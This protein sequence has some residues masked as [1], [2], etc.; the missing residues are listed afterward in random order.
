MLPFRIALLSGKA[1]IV[2]WLSVVT[3]NNRCVVNHPQYC[4]ITE[5]EDLSI[6]YFIS[7]GKKGLI[8]KVISFRKT[9]DPD[10]YNLSFGDYC[11]GKIPDDSVI[12]DNGDRDKVLATVVHAMHVYTAKYPYRWIFAQGSTP[13]RTRLYRMLINN[14]FEELSQ[15][16]DFYTVVDEAVYPFD[17]DKA[18]TAFLIKRKM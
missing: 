4:L 6:F 5:P 16:Y 2:I 14:R 12:T 1:V 7:E 11:S 9:W 17:A 8:R 13:S 15:W 3:V 10:I 18:A